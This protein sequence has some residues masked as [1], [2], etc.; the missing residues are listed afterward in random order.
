MEGK[1]KKEGRE[2]E[3]DIMFICGICMAQVS[4]S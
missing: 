4:R 1:K 3:K 2:N